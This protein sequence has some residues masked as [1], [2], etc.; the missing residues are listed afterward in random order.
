MM[1]ASGIRKRF[2]FSLS[3]V[4]GVFVIALCT[5]IW[6][7]NRNNVQQ[8]DTITRREAI[9]TLS[10]QTGGDVT[11]LREVIRLRL[12]APN[13]KASIKQQEAIQKSLENSLSKLT[14]LTP[15]DSAAQT[16]VS[17]L[18]RAYYQGMKPLIARIEHLLLTD[19]A[20]ARKVFQ[21]ELLPLC[22]QFEEHTLKAMTVAREDAG[23]ALSSN[24]SFLLAGL[25]LAFGM[26]MIP[27]VLCKIQGPALDHELRK[28]VAASLPP[29]P[30]PEIIKENEKL[31]ADMDKLQ[32]EKQTETDSHEK[33]KRELS[34]AYKAAAQACA[35]LPPAE[36]VPKAVEQILNALPGKVSAA[37]LSSNR[38]GMSMDLDRSCIDRTRSILQQKANWLRSPNDLNLP[39]S[40]NK[41]RILVAED[42]SL[43]RQILRRIL[44][45]EED[46]EVLMFENGKS[47]WEKMDSGTIPDICLLDNLMP[48]MDG[49][50]LLQKIRND[51][52]FKHT[53]VIMCSATSDRDDVERAINLSVSHFLVKPYVPD[54]VLNTIKQVLLAAPE[55]TAHQRL[56]VSADEYN[57]MARTLAEESSKNL[58]AARD[59]FLNGKY[60]NASIR[61]NALKGASL[62]LGNEEMAQ[63]AD[64][65]DHSL[66]TGYLPRIMEEFDHLE[67]K[68]HQLN[69]MIAG[70][71]Q[72]KAEP[73]PTGRT[74]A[75]SPAESTA[76]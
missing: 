56:G 6:F 53:R 2:N 62:S 57:D 38:L 49:L 31:K 22:S 52:R 40:S 47:A 28:A 10:V 7:S 1:N 69:A 66:Q 35:P 71:M 58:S 72:A 51:L 17:S 50:Q 44:S 67:E 61:I 45:S 33:T 21:G 39:I 13:D 23:R 65:L 36:A 63:I 4:T 16:T 11:R 18:G 34:A 25:C 55:I 60:R 27:F 43:S 30:A 59:D 29:P 14:S 9:V 73:A 24:V 70:Q 64:K 8:L 15:N 54:L 48:E 75:T 20:G 32:K 5:I 12:D 42:D 26:L 74:V 3:A 19:L 68:V 41:T 37:S 76:G 46:W